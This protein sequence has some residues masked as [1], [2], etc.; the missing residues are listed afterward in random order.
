MFI[1][2]QQINEVSSA[3]ALAQKKIVNPTKQS[4]NPY[5]KSKYANLEA[6]IE[7]SKEALLEQGINVLQI[8]CTNEGKDALLTLLLHT[9]GQ[10]VGGYYSLVAKDNTPQG[11]GSAISYARRYGLMAILN[12][13]QEDDDGAAASGTVR[14]VLPALAKP[15]VK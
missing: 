7:V 1:M 14:P 2:S 5:F 13:A 4:A 15:P 8:V 11:V 12:L 6:V 3:L 9:S 10:F